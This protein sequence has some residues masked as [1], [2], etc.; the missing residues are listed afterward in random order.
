MFHDRKIITFRISSELYYYGC[1]TTIF[2]NLRVENGTAL[3][4]DWSTFY[5]RELLLNNGSAAAALPTHVA[6]AAAAAATSD[7][8]FL[9]HFAAAAAAAAAAASIQAPQSQQ[10]ATTFHPSLLSTSQH[11]TS[12]F[13]TA[14]SGQQVR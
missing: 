14:V 7:A 5:P 13:P 11:Q 6:A 9:N 2:L 4:T 12:T 3:A 10:P 1:D 8:S